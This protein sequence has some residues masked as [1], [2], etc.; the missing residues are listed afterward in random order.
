MAFIMLITVV[1]PL[2]KTFPFSYA[3]SLFRICFFLFRVRVFKSQARV[4]VRV[5]SKTSPGFSRERI[6]F[7]SGF[8][9]SPVRVSKYACPYCKDDI[10]ES[11][12]SSGI[13]P[14][15][16]SFSIL[17]SSWPMKRLAYEGPKHRRTHSTALGLKIL[18]ITE[19]KIVVMN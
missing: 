15:G 3:E 7:E 16:A 19:L 14:P 8:S 10:D 6:F 5:F 1:K 4:T 13:N 2:Q 9:S 12:H 17:Y 18:F 11:Y